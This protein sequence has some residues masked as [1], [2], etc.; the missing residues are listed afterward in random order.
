MGHVRIDV[1]AADDQP[2]KQIGNMTACLQL[3]T[4]RTQSLLQEQQA[5]CFKC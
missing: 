3:G 5:D 4:L 1:Q 2:M